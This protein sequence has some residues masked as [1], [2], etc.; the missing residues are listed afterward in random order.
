MRSDV[1][2]RRATI[3]SALVPTYLVLI[4]GVPL[5]LVSVPVVYAESASVRLLSL[6]I[7]PV[8][9]VCGL[10]LVAGALSRMTLSSVVPGSYPRMLGHRIYGPRRL[11]ALCW[12]AIYYSQPIY[13][14]V[15]AVP[16][17]KRLVFRAFGYHGSLDFQTYPDT[18]LRDL[19]LLSI[20]K[21]AYLSNKATVSPNMCLRSGKIIVLPVSI[22][23]RAMIGHLTMIAP[24][25]EVG[26]DSEVGVGSAI[27]INVSIGVR[28]IVDPEVV[29]DHDAAIGDGCVIGTRSYIGRKAVV[30][31]GVRLPPGT[32]VP[33]RTVLTTQADVVALFGSEAAGISTSPFVRLTLSRGI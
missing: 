28:T 5:A 26:A 30:R 20:G 21:G 1:S 2:Q 8:A 9:Y 18:W 3:I 27:G 25:A 29:I 6:A 15:L 17:L 33:A 14:A 12:T 22:G 16:V 10:L 4:V 13:H 19:P 7:A 11:Y 24:G 23:A 31:S 32:I